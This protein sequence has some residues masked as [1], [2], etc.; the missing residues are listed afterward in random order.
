MSTNL[1]KLLRTTLTVSLIAAVLWQVGDFRQILDVL[2]RVDPLL[3][4]VTLL[5]ITLDRALMTYKWVYLLHSHGQTLPILNGMKIYCA[6]AMWGIAL[7]ST[8]GADAIRAYLT[9]RSGLDS[10]TV[11]TS[12]I[13]ERMVGFIASLL[14]A[15]ISIAILNSQ[16]SL[17]ERIGGLLWLAALL[18]AACIF[19][20]ATSFSNRLFR[21]I[22]EKWL[23]RFREKSIFAKLERLHQSYLNYALRKKELGTFFGLSFIE[24]FFSFIIAWLIAQSLDVDV[25][26]LFMAG[27]IPV[28]LLLSRLPI[29]I[30]GIGVFEAI[31]VLAMSAA[32]VSP[33]EA[34]TIAFGARI[35]QI[36]AWMPWW[37]AHMLENRQFSLKLPEAGN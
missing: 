35:L 6:S 36:V 33:A 34:V 26:L 8:V 12:I 29:S 5:V 17:D 3:T 1:N 7:P 11:I 14:L 15:L 13:V 28:T 18:L 4:L 21:L 20:F 19:L 24:Q 22:H 31:F 23:A 25:G 9:A 10:K 30:D 32:G 27:V 2:G 37:F 16:I